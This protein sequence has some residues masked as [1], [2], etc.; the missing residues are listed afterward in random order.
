MGYKGI[1]QGSVLQWIKET[2]EGKE[3]TD[4]RSPAGNW[5]SFTLEH[6]EKGSATL[7]IMVRHEM[8]NPYGNIHGGMMALVIDETMG[9]AVASLDT[10]TH[11][12]SMSLNIDFLYAIKGGDRL[13]SV[14]KVIRAGKRIYNVECSVYDMQDKLLA[15]GSS[16]L[17]VT[18]MDFV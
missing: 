5:L 13:R 10:S 8:T 15:K 3:V 6:I 18:S 17:I 9:W 11:Y 1:P 7:N 4:S 2:Y 12:T 16:N 14:A